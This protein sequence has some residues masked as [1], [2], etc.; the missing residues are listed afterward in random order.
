VL[1]QRKLAIGQAA[2]PVLAAIEVPEVEAA[3]RATANAAGPESPQGGA[4][5][6]AVVEV[7]GVAHRVGPGPAQADRPPPSGCRFR[8]PRPGAAQI[9][10]GGKAEGHGVGA[11]RA[12]LSETAEA[13]RV[14]WVSTCFGSPPMCR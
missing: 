14:A 2:E 7:A 8:F 3:V 10:E 4:V 11:D 6:G 1:K 5:V 13:G 12:S 9:Q